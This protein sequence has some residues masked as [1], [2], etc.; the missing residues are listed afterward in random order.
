MLNP[1]AESIEFAASVDFAP[2]P[3]ISL[4]EALNQFNP[5]QGFNLGSTELVERTVRYGFRAAGFS[6]LIHEGINSEVVPIMPFAVI[7]NTPNWLVGIVN[8]HGNLVPVCDLVQVSTGSQVPQTAGNMILV[9]GKGDSV[10]GFIIEGYPHA[11]VNPQKTNHIVGI[12]EWLA[13]AVTSAF[14]SN[15]EVWLEFD[16]ESFLQKAK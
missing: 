13:H 2:R 5:P 1:S 8:L 9:L 6:F 10:A 15:N 11:V 14:I 4:G 16:Y 12:P 3:L 7:P